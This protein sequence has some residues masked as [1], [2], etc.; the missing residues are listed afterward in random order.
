MDNNEQ[1]E[2]KWAEAEK[3][4][5]GEEFSIFVSVGEKPLTQR[6]FNLFHFFEYIAGQAKEH[7][8]KTAVEVGC[9][10][11]TISL[12]LNKYLGMEVTATDVSDEAIEL[13]QKNFDYHQGVG[14]IIKADAEKLPFADDTFNLAVSIG[15]VEHFEDYGRVYTEQY[16]V[17]K[18]GGV[19]IS[20][21]V[22]RKQSIQILNDI[23][24]YFKKISGSKLKK[25]YF[26]NT[27][28]PD[29]YKKA[30]GTAGFQNVS[31]F[32]VN[33]FPLFTPASS[34]TEKILASLYN[35]I[36]RLRGL[37]M[38][39][40]FKGSKLLSQAHFLTAKK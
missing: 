4:N 33:S 21:N 2:K 16:R 31:T 24:R 26:R 30:A 23:Y 7:K 25:D 19:M 40:P 39:Y 3:K 10:R 5:T 12:Y 14:N 29:D 28:K 6:Q 15:L 22:P 13:A 32:Y 18:P 11:G 35:F 9:G 36:Y 38:P 37:V 20:L 27:D 1:F 34:K 17:L 8:C